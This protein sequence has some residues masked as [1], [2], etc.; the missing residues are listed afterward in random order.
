MDQ[1]TAKKLL[2]LVNNQQMLNA[3]EVYI[4][5]RLNLA[6]RDLEQMKDP[7]SLYGLQ[8]QVLELKKFY[9]LKD[10]VISKAKGS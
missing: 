7:I 5:Y 10:E 6:R 2:P 3:L 1:E 8:G 9:T 4:D